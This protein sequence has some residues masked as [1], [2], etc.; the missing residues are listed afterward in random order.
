MMT[1]DWEAVAAVQ[2]HDDC[3]DADRKQKRVGWANGR[4]HCSPLTGV[5]VLPYQTIEALMYRNPK[6]LKAVASSLP[7]VRQRRHTSG[8]R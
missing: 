5:D 3:D 6:L 7:G 4:R 1:M 8:P 2:D